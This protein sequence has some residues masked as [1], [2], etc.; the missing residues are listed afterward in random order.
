MGE[1]PY[2]DIPVVPNSE[3]MVQKRKTTERKESYDIALTNESKDEERVVKEVL[4]KQTKRRP[5]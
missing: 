1:G 2:E 4:E 5:G 3:E